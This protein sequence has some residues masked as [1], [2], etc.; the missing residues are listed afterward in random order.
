MF[1]I[2]VINI[3]ALYLK[4]KA[5]YLKPCSCSFLY[6]FDAR[7]RSPITWLSLISR[8][9]INR[10]DTFTQSFKYFK[11]G[12]FKVV[13]KQGGRS[14]FYIGDGITKFPFYWTSNPWRYKG[15]TREELSVADKEMV[16]VV[17]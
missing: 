9:R 12:F 15:L 13:V 11:D 2:L 6:F 5:L 14:H 3:G 1:E 7:P 8:P 16:D 10:L 4:C 17:M